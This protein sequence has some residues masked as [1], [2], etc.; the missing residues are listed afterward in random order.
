MAT[1]SD[2]SDLSAA[3]RKKRPVRMTGAPY[4]F[5]GPPERKIDVD[6]SI[7]IYYDI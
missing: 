2:P 1:G 5:V 4:G 7:L 3:V 6:K